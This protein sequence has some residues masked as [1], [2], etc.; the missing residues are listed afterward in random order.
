VNV[1]AVRAFVLVAE[2][3][4]YQDAADELGISQQ[5]VSKRI[6]ALEQQVGVPLLVRSRLTADGET[7][8]PHARQI[9]GSIQAALESVR[10]RKRAL[11]VDVIGSRLIS[12]ELVV[13]FHARHP[14]VEVEMVGLRG[15]GAA[16]TALLDGSIDAAFC[17]P[18]SV[19]AALDHRRV[20]DEPLDLIVGS[21][22]PLAG[23]RAIRLADLWEH[24]VWVPG[25]VD[26]SDW[27]A[28]YA[29]LA[30]DFGLR[31]DDTGPNFGADHLL[32]TIAGSPSRATF[33]GPSFRTAGHDVRRVKIRQPTPIYPWSLAWHRV[34][35]HPGLVGLRAYLEARP[36]TAAQ[37]VWSPPA[38]R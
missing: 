32:G 1:D 2:W 13:D 30:V 8:L 29:A 23:K 20:H 7:F 28:Y 10:P 37:P 14:E 9:L 3:G 15:P 22:H 18:A 35:G 12:A 26:G 33:A 19:P 34:N 11:R 6:A 17:S 38:R 31:I 25:I 24:P 4:R 21:R 36:A 16:F 27:G 5:A